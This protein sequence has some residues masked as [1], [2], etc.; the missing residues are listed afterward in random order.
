MSIQERS[1]SVLG[2]F[3]WAFFARFGW[4]IGGKVYHLVF[5]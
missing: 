5:R 1:W 2:A 3:F 4:E